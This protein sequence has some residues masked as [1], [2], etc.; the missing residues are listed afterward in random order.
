LSDLDPLIDVVAAPHWLL[1][2]FIA[3]GGWIAK[4]IIGRHLKT[5]DKLVDIT[6]ET[7]EVAKALDGRVSR[8]EG[9]F[10]ERDRYGHSTWPG[11][12]R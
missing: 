10:L 8:L 3:I 6:T 5:L 7:N 4:L 12:S 11:D 9:R 1:V 2:P